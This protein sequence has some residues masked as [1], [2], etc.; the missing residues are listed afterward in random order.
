MEP[1]RARDPVKSILLPRGTGTH[2]EKSDR[3]QQIQRLVTNEEAGR[4]PSGQEA[5]EGPRGDPVGPGAW[6]RPLAGGETSAPRKGGHGFSGGSSC[7]MGR[8]TEFSV[9]VILLSSLPIGEPLLLLE[10]RDQWRRETRGSAAWG[11]GE[12]GSPF[13][14]NFQRW[15]HPS[16][17]FEYL[18]Q[19]STHLLHTLSTSQ[20]KLLALPTPPETGKARVIL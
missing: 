7:P 19:I 2:R 10:A 5:A 1:W 9:T 11:V 4:H 12:G 6:G 17:F 8:Q 20:H 3:E 13:A 16:Y 18:Y 15:R 14:R